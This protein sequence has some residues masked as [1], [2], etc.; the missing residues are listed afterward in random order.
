MEKYFGDEFELHT[1]KHVWSEES[2]QWMRELQVDMG[3]MDIV[4]RAEV[5]CGVKEEDYSNC[6]GDGQRRELFECIAGSIAVWRD[7]CVAA[8]RTF[9][10][11]KV[12]NMIEKEEV[13]E[14]KVI[15]KR[16]EEGSRVFNYTKEVI[17][18]DVLVDLDRGGN[19]VPISFHSKKRVLERYDKE[20]WN[21][22]RGYHRLVLRG[23]NCRGMLEGDFVRGAKMSAALQEL[24]LSC[25]SD[26]SVGDD[27]CEF[28]LNLIE[29]HDA[30]REGMVLQVEV[31]ESMSMA[32]GLTVKELEK[33][34]TFSDSVFMEADKKLGIA[35][36]PLSLI[37]DATREFL[38][39]S[40]YVKV[41]GDNDEVLCVLRGKV[42][43]VIESIDSE[44]EKFLGWKVMK[45]LRG[46]GAGKLGCLRMVPKVHKKKEKLEF[47]PIR[48]A[49]ED[50]GNVISR[51]LNDILKGVM[52]GL[53]VKFEEVT[54]RSFSNLPGTEAFMEQIKSMNCELG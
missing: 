49:E 18:A 52:E 9:K 29:Q 48:A 40:G 23:R 4:G 22:I 54:G 47:R 41:E 7:G 3:I 6:R 21:Y 50:P 31:A 33:K 53:A 24:Y 11:D 32:T 26:D 37:V 43:K 12:Y 2:M 46:R 42:T 14:E 8:C 17:P 45:N 16:L 28:Y 27:R 1:V 39:G 34:Y 36:V 13:E 10:A 15:D 25:A 30:M 19:F 44:E 20:L 51:A 38:E 5:M 35:L